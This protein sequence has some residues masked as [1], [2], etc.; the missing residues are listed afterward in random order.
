MKETWVCDKVFKNILLL[1]DGTIPMLLDTGSFERTLNIFTYLVRN[2]HN[3]E[4][5]DDTLK[6]KAKPFGDEYQRLIHSLR[7]IQRV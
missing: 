5:S 1:H 3:I 2:T 7:N 6:I 4:D